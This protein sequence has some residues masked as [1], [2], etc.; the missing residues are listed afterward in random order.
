LRVDL[1]DGEHRGHT[2]VDSS[3]F[4]TLVAVEADTDRMRTP[5]G[6]MFGNDGIAQWMVGGST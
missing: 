1:G 6:R 4:P 2:K 3:G 5:L